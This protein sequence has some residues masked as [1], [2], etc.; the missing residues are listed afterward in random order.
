M[1]CPGRSTFLVGGSPSGMTIYRW[2]DAPVAGGVLF[3]EFV[4][5][6]TVLANTSYYLE[7]EDLNG[8]RSTRTQIDII[9]E[10]NDDVPVATRKPTCNL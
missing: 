5:N 4:Y 8:C 2:Y 3:N 6:P 9:A 10:D 7:T 1:L